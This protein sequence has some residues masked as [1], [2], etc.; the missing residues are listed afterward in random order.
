M[1]LILGIFIPIIAYILMQDRINSICTA[2]ARATST[3][4]TDSVVLENIQK[5]KD[6]L[7]SGAITQEEFDA[8][9]KEFLDL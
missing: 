1:C 7:D 9:K 8:K 5:L 4:N 3:K 6:L 2:P